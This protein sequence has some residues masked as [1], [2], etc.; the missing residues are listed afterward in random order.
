MDLFLFKLIITPF[1]LVAATL[2]TRRWGQT[3]GG[4][5]VG[6]PLTSGPV[7]V[8]LALEQGPEFTAAAA[9]GT[10]NGLIAV[11]F[12]CMAYARFAVGCK[13][14]LASLLAFGVY[15]VGVLLFSS[16]FLPFFCSVFL[17]ILLLILG[18]WYIK[19]ATA[20]IKTLSPPWWDLPF[21]IIAATS[22]VLS[23]TSASSR[24]GPELSGLLS[25][26]PVFVSVMAAFSHGLYGADA[27]K[28]FV[29]GVL[30]GSYSFIAYFTF[31]FL[32]VQTWNF[33]WVYVLAL[34]GALAA[35]G[36]VFAFL[37]RAQK[38]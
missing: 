32:T 5:L 24:L 27:A 29:R 7:S 18:A 3:I 34:A 8:F 2:T 4:L 21:R 37:A 35:N 25:G 31:V 33:L 22:I 12:F 9:H 1:L 28:N 20:A 14:P 11:I 13:W 19:P 15:F 6:L 23:I 36:M 17:G 10:I 26:F 16:P 38:R 30:V